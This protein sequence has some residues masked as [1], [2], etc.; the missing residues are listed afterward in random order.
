MQA[1]CEQ[2]EHPIFI[3]YDGRTDRAGNDR[4]VPRS[5]LRGPITAVTASISKPPATVPAF[6]APATFTASTIAAPVA[7]ILNL[8][9]P[10]VTIPTF[11]MCST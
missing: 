3:S 9:S 6:T 8:T 10:N 1:S 4:V 2:P 5:S 11:H 7:T